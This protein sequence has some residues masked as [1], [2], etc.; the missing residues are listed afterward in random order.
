MY[1]SLRGIADNDCYNYEFLDSEILEHFLLLLISYNIVYIASDD[2][3][4]LTTTGEKLL[5][6]LNSAVEINGYSNKIYRNEHTK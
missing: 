2:R 3:V 1:Y 4:L 5:Q 6:Y